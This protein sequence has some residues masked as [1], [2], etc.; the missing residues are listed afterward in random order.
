[1]LAK[2]IPEHPTSDK[3][4]VWGAVAC[5]H[6]R[7]REKKPVIFSKGFCPQWLKI[8]LKK[9][10]GT[11]KRSIQL[12][13]Q[14]KTWK[15]VCWSFFFLSFLLFGK[16]CFSVSMSSWKWDRG[17]CMCMSVPPPQTH[18]WPARLTSWQLGWGIASITW[19]VTFQ[20]AREQKQSS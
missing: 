12:H 16:D 15:V 4:T 18:T 7:I 20:R 13:R 6:A 3:S 8:K 2:S 11:T 19:P 5:I 14:S 1:M 17:F 9:H 10:L